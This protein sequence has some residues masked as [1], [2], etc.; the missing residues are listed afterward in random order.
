MALS[1]NM[2]GEQHYFSSQEGNTGVVQLEGE[3]TID[4]VPAVRASLEAGKLEA[5][6]ISGASLKKL[7]TAGALMIVKTLN[8]TG[9]KMQDFRQDHAELVS[10]VA[11][12]HEKS[13][14]TTRAK[15]VGRILLEDVGRSVVMAALDLAEML[16]N[17]GH[18][19]A[20]F[21]RI[22]V[23]RASLRFTSVV[24]HIEHAGLRA[25][26]IVALMS[27]LI[28]GI[29]AQQGAYQLRAF[30]AELL[31][32]NLSGI[33]IMREIGLLL[34]AIMFAG[35]S[36]SAFTAELGSMKMREEIDALRIMGRDP[37]E[38]LVAPRV[39]A[40]VIALPL[41]TLIANGSALFGAM[42]VSWIYIGIEPMTFMARLQNVIT[43]NIFFV[44]LIKAPLMALV[45][46]IVGY[47][48]GMKVKGS[49]E[50]LGQRVT[51]SVVK[52]IFMVIVMDGV[53]AIVF[54]AFDF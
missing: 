6:V 48:E 25:T 20:A 30:G 17:L 40:L 42:I 4:T 49:A 14:N 12:A 38:V 8:L 13:F 29:I 47:M 1:K 27:F 36:G 10:N 24:Y 19:I 7:D 46:G 41:L 33:L 39:L 44:G 28:G 22:I 37:V 26:P 50:S 15:G 51:S 45:I 23:G 43:P 35:R 54:A 31:T 3:W 21:Y 5:S 11:E 34:A 2:D 16:K 9:A 32:V 52:A 18:I 53:F